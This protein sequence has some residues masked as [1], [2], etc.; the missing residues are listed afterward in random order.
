MTATMEREHVRHVCDT[1]TARV[2]QGRGGAPVS[3]GQLVELWPQC[4]RAELAAPRPTWSLPVVAHMLEQRATPRER[5][6][7]R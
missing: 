3:E 6:E 1:A 2:V 5:D 4:I 7:E